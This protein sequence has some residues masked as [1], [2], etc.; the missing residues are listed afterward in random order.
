MPY[1]VRPFLAVSRTTLSDPAT[2]ERYPF[3]GLFT[4]VDLPAGAFLGFY[5]GKIRDGE[6][7]GKD[8]YCISGSEVHVRPVK[9]KGVVRP[10][11]YPLAMVNEPPPDTE[12]NTSIVEFST[13]GGV[14]PGLP[15]KTSIF[16][17]GFFTCA[18]VRA[19]S[20]LF[21]NYGKGYDRSH[22]PNPLDVPVSRMVGK[23]CRP[24]LKAQ[25]ERPVDMMAKYG[26][27]R[28]DADCF[29]VLE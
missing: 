7:R 2:G 21:V 12:A 25:R 22:Y 26:I 15:S 3:A 27:D 8:R 1:L 16:A 4:T 17:I 9:T 23:T 13:A 11:E 14:V 28:V 6:Y 29:A 19:G 10:E 24:P 5:N 20:E 18:P